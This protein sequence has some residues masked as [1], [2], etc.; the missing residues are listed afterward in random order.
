LKHY[1]LLEDGMLS[2]ARVEV[3]DACHVCLEEDNI[4]LMHEVKELDGSTWEAT[5]LGPS[6]SLKVHV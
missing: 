1:Q 2:A 3:P 6:T 4:E 5:V